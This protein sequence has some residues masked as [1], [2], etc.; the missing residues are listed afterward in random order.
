MRRALL[1]FR[2]AGIRTTIPFHLEVL[3]GEEFAAGRFDIAWVD[4]N[5][6]GL[7]SRLA[8]SPGPLAEAAAVAA[9]LYAFESSG[10]GRPLGV[11][12]ASPWAVAGRRAQMIGRPPRGWV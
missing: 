11:A 9:A 12:A 1:E 2:I 8:E 5:L 4:R 6:P 10:A 3:G 7:V